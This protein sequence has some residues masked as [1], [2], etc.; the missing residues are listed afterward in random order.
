MWVLA[1][2]W[3][4][5]GETRAIF[6]GMKTQVT[7]SLTIELVSKLKQVAET[8]GVSMNHAV[9]TGLRSLVGL[10]S[11]PVPRP[12]RPKADQAA[13][14]RAPGRPKSKPSVYSVALPARTWDLL[15]RCAQL[16]GVDVAY[17]LEEGWPGCKRVKNSIVG[18]FEGLA[19]E[20]GV[21]EQLKRFMTM[22]REKHG[23]G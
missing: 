6:Q 7:F 8:A 4:V 12:G 19:D 15:N 10:P 13:P 21:H 18:S 11:L 3:L 22:V 14:K 1:G 17:V 16:E 20:T 2:I 9:E 5:S 23:I